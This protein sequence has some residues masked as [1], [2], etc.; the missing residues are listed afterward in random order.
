MNSVSAPTTPVLSLKAQQLCELTLLSEALE[1]QM[2]SLCSELGRLSQ[3]KFVL[4]SA[5]EIALT[6]L[7]HD[8]RE[9]QRAYCAPRR[10]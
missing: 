8:Q 3:E 1:A 2:Q 4:D 10:F 7:Q 6:E 5:I 9:Y